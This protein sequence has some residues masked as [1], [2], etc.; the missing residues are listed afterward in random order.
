MNLRIP[1]RGRGGGRQVRIGAFQRGLSLVEVLVTV[2][3]LAIGLIGIG[4]MQLVG[5]QG[6]QGA[7]F[8]TQATYVAYEAADNL[9][10]NRGAVVATG[11]VPPAAVAIWSQVAEQLLP[12]GAVEVAVLDA[13]QGLVRITV[14]WLDDRA[15]A[16]PNGGMAEFVL[17]TR[18]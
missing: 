4:A 17:A 14:R 2:V 13:N 18:I 12:Q 1:Q 9:R 3:I 16:A 10:A 6:N 11:G 15:D 5:L 7:Y 8:R